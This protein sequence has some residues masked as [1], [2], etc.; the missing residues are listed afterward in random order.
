MDDKNKYY[1]LKNI[2][3]INN[4]EIRFLFEFRELLQE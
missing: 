4:N 3:I 2:E 1:I